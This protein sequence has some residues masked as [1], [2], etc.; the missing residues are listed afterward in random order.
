LYIAAYSDVV[1]AETDWN[2]LEGLQDAGEVKL[3]GLVLVTRDADGKSDVKDTAHTVGKG[4][5]WGA[6]GGAIVGLIFPPAFLTS[7]AVGTGIGAGIG[8][9]VSHGD[10]Q[11][12]KEDVEDVLPNNSSGIVALMEDQWAERVEQILSRANKVTKRD[13]DAES[14]DQVKQKAG[15]S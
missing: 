12:I 15:S 4:A 5:G 3:D 13:V 10:K 8:G 6:V 7:A 9:I 2:E 11:E 1:A 14:A